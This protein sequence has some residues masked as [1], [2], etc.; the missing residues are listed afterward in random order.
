MRITMFMVLFMSF[1]L[2]GME[3]NTPKEVST[4][5]P[6]PRIPV[7]ADYNALSE[8]DKKIYNAQ[9]A[10]RFYSFS[11]HLYDPYLFTHKEY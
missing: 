2:A 10:R 1:S 8:N 6:M 5:P 4:V 3:T 9:R 7:N 11:K